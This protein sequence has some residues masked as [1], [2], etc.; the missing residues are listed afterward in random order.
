MKGTPKQIEWAK[1]IKKEA[2]WKF[3][4]L[5]DVIEVCM[6]TQEEVEALAKED[7]AEFWINALKSPTEEK[8]FMFLT[9]N[10][11]HPKV[12]EFLNDYENRKKYMHELC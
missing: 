6:P 4:G 9:R 1:D 2:M 5:R 12:K 8:V 10:M 11:L 7:D 3:R